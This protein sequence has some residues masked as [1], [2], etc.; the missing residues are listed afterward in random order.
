MNAKYSPPVIRASPVAPTRLIIPVLGVVD[1][2]VV[3]AG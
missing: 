2:C 1:V 3:S